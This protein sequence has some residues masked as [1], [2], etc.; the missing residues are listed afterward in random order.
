MVKDGS[1]NDLERLQELTKGREWGFENDPGPMRDIP[2]DDVYELLAEMGTKPED[3][4]DP[5]DR[6]GYESFLKKWKKP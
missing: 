6:V 3:L 5:E 2:D 1:K 4:P